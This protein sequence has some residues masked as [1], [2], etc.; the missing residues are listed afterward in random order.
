MKNEEQW[1]DAWMDG[2]E[3]EQCSAMLYPLIEQGSMVGP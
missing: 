2:L 3:G 1:M